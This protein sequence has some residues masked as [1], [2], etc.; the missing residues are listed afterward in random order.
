MKRRS[1]LP[2]MVLAS[3]VAACGAVVPTQDLPCPCDPGFVCCDRVCKAEGSCVDTTLGPGCEQ[4]SDG[5]SCGSDTGFASPDG[6][7]GEEDGSSASRAEAGVDA[8]VAEGGASTNAYCYYAS[9]PGG[10]NCSY[11]NGM[12]E[13]MSFECGC[14]GTQGNA[15]TAAQTELDC[16]S[17]GGSIV[18]VCPSE[19]LVGCCT[20]SYGDFA[21]LSPYPEGNTVACSYGAD[22]QYELHCEAFGGTWS[23][24]A[25]K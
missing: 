12:P 11:E 9:H 17:G 3:V 2:S 25:P 14:M 15:A 20:S 21:G 5:S 6:G 1:F 19:N 7:T 16:M 10:D 4:G 22:M 8:D 18:P 24:I 23:S 13:S